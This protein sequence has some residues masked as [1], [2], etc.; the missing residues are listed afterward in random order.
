MSL[1]IKSYVTT[2]PKAIL[3]RA[4]SINYRHQGN[5]YAKAA[6]KTLPLFVK[7][8]FTKVDEI[9]LAVNEKNIGAKNCMIV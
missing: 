7:N 1:N 8:H 6:M 9:V 4:L 5:G 3:L 2:N